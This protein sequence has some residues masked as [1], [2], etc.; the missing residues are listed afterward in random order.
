M[1][2][3]LFFS[4]Y[5]AFSTRDIAI[6]RIVTLSVQNSHGLCFATER[7]RLRAPTATC[8]FNSPTIAPRICGMPEHK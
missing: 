7:S 8:C 4:T 1:L 3:L 5:P 6:V 2:L